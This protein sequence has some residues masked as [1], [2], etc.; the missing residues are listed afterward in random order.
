MD[1]IK[2]K[3]MDRSQFMKNSTPAIVSRLPSLTLTVL[4]AV[5]M[6]MS[7]ATQGV[8]ADQTLANHKVVIQSSNSD[9]ELQ[10]L[11]LVI[12]SNLQKHYGMDNVEIEVV[13]YGPGFGILTKGNP[14]EQKVVNLIA[15]DVKFSACEGTM[16]FIASQNKGKMPD[17]IKGVG[18]VPDGAVRVIELQ[19][20]GYSYLYP[21]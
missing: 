12:A 18:T 16:K 10:G 11:A 17:L 8:F 1:V 9:P 15:Q 3:T 13:G 2:N 4:W 19:E 21:R 5:A 20:Q 14:N 6:L 7:I